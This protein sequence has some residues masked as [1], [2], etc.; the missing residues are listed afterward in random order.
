M[1]ITNRETKTASPSTFATPCTSQTIPIPRARNSSETVMIPA[2][3]PTH[4][5]SFS[6]DAELEIVSD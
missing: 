2:S 6:D 4:A 3:F 1:G 5:V